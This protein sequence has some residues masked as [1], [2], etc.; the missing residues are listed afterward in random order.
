MIDKDI[1]QWLLWAREL[2]SIGQ[3]GLTYAKDDY[4]RQNYKKMLE[5]SAEMIEKKTE[6]SK[7]NIL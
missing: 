5:I 1:P 2:Q 6:I 4:D 3:I 7:D